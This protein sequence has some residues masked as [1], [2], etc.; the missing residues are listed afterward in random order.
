MSMKKWSV[1][2]ITCQLNVVVV[3]EF[4]SYILSFF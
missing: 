4:I 1:V 3:D 2:G